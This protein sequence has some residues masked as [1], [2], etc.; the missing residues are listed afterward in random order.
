MKYIVSELADNQANVQISSLGV[1][2]TNI[3]DNQ[4]GDRNRSQVINDIV[5]RSK[6]SD[7]NVAGDDF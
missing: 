2:D 3:T 4:R 6:F 1:D 5:T 7:D